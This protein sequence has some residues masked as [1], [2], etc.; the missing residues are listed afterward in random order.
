MISSTIHHLKGWLRDLAPLINGCMKNSMVDL[1]I[2]NKLGIK[3]RLNTAPKIIEV[4]WLPPH[5]SWIKINTNGM[6]LGS[7][8]LAAIGGIFRNSRGFSK[9]CFC[10]NIGIQNA[11]VAEL[12]AFITAVN[13]AWQNNWFQVWFEMDSKA[14]V[15]CI[16]NYNFK[17]PWQ[18]IN[19][20]ANCQNKLKQMQHYI[21]HVYREGNQA[22][23]Y[24]SKMGLKYTNLKWWNAF[25][26]QLSTYLAH[27]YANL[28]N[29]RFK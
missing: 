5:H 7:P 2:I 21:S 9:G 15:D 26:Q 13:L 6:A 4:S 16:Q 18:L 1:S 20:W 17:P 11:F 19:S 24:L 27:D 25:P 29:Y 23:D 14:V 12:T 10:K 28:P 8:G 3:G 22:A